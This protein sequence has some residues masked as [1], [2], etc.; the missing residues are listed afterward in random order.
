M[1]AAGWPADVRGQHGA[2]PLHW[3]AL[4]GNTEMVALLLRYHPLLESVDHDFHATPLGW[5]IHGSEHEHCRT[6]N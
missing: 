4:E 3:A 6:G 5:A 1:L 2:T